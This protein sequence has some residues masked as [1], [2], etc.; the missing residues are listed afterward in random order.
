[1]GA[2]PVVQPNQQVLIDIKPPAYVSFS[3]EIV[4]Q[5]V[6]VLLGSIA[7]LVNQGHQEIHLLL[8]SP[9]GS[10]MHGITAYNFLWALPIKLITHNIGNVDSIGTVV[11]LAGEE[12]YASPHTTFMLHG[13]ALSAT[14]PVTFFERNLAEKLASVQADQAR[15]KGIYTE[16]SNITEAEAEGYF[17]GE[18]TL[19]AAAALERGLVHEVRQISI[20][21][22]SPILQLVFNR[23]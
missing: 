18:D 20:P 13:V 5:T 23:Q 9:G 19:N 3:A 2:A 21:A 16:R 12:R 22:G 7:N 11:F 15:I 14:S 8:S 1:M 4:P 10:V 6:E 17:L